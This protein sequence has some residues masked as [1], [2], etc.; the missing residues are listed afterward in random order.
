V[1]SI[2]F[3]YYDADG[4]L[5]AASD[6]AKVAVEFGVEHAHHSAR[7]TSAVKLRNK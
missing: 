7:L 5:A 6:A 1:S 3:Q 2:V 4:Q